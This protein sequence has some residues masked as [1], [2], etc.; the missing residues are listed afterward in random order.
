[1]TMFLLKVHM[2]SHMIHQMSCPRI[3]I[4]I[5]HI[6]HIPIL[7]IYLNKVNQLEHERNQKT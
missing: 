4:A 7:Y 2:N 1:M 5:A 6:A 3:A